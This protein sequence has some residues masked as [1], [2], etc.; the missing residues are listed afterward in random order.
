MAEATAGSKFKLYIILSI[1]GLIF[2]LLG[3]IILKKIIAWIVFAGMLA[4]IVG[5]VYW[6]RSKGSPTS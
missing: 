3:A 2:V 1:A 4:L 5:V 6:A